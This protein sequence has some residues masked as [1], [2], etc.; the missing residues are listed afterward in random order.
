[1][2]RLRSRSRWS[3]TLGS[4][5]V[6][7]DEGGA[8]QGA[9][10]P[11]HEGDMNRV[12]AMRDLALLTD[13]ESP[14]TLTAAILYFVE[15]HTLDEVGRVLDLPRQTVSKMLRQFAARARK[16]SARLGPGGLS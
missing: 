12:E 5:D 8:P 2:D 4:L 1:V 10:V 9:W 6:P 14:E 13:G 3:G 16:R 11:S 15:G 7:D